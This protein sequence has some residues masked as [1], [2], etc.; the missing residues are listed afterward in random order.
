MIYPTTKEEYWEIIDEH[1]DALLGVIGSY[2]PLNSM[3]IINEE[4]CEV[5]PSEK[6]MWRHI[7]KLKEDRDPHIARYFFAVWDAAP[8]QPYIHQGAWDI[9]CNLC[10]EE[11]VLDEN[12]DN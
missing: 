7:L 1:W 6:E 11:Y 12:E 2:L 10:S 4:N 3:E 5:V 9:L 8:D